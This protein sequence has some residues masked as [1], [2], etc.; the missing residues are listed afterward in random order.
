MTRP[1]ALISALADAALTVVLGFGVPVLAVTIGWLAGGAFATTPWSAQYLIAGSVWALG[2]GGGVGV[3]VDP[4]AFPQLGLTEPL[5][6][7]I[8]LAPLAVTAFVIWSGWRSGRRLAAERS[9]WLGGLAGIAAFAI[10]TSFSLAPAAGGAVQVDVTGAVVIGT[11]SYAVPLIL[12]AAPP[13]PAL[14]TAAG[15]P[16]GVTRQLQ[17][18]LRLAAALLVGLVA[19]ASVIVLVLIAMRMGTVIGLMQSLQLD[20]WGVLG[21]ALLQLAYLPTLVVW[22][23]CWL[24]GAPIA[25]GAGSSVALGGATAGP[26]PALP[27]LGLLPEGT[28]PLL[29]ALVAVVVLGAAAARLAFRWNDEEGRDGSTVWSRL[30]V[31]VGGAVIAALVVA[32]AA[33]LASGSI[34][35]G[36]M[37]DI[38]PHAG[39]TFAWAFGLLV[40]GALAGEWIPLDR[41]DRA[42]DAATAAAD[43]IRDRARTATSIRADG[44]AGDARAP[45]PRSAPHL[46]TPPTSTPSR[47]TPARSPAARAESSAERPASAMP[48]ASGEPAVAEPGDSAARRARHGDSESRESADGATAPGSTAG[49]APH[50]TGRRRTADRELG[51]A[52]RR[53][54]EPDIYADIDEDELR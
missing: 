37:A 27:L 38:G 50:A 10:A 3:T 14:L 36:R 6:F 21:A 32:L 22:M 43:G 23:G 26:L 9:P 46:S 5:A 18:A 34:G 8:S 44:E 16:A 25:L 48:G 54:D 2:L 39:V 42:R 11:L 13:L 30:I 19:A 35:P 12:A 51:D 15:V 33:Y 41:V 31:P 28:T 53:P 45:S 24:L 4:A 7:T 49:H 1:A 29:W 52:V 17:R 20:V 40:I 47:S